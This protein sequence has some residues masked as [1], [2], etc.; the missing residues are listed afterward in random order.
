MTLL[1]RNPE[2]GPRKRRVIAL[3]M[4]SVLIATGGVVAV[5]APAAAAD[6]A[7]VPWMDPAKSADERAQALLDASSQHQKYRWLV[8]Q[9]ANSPQQTTWFGGVVYPVQ[10]ECTPTVIYANGP[11]G[12]YGSRGTTAWP[13][14]IAVAATWDLALGQQKA[15]AHG[16]ESF[17]KRSAVVLGPG[18]A[19]GRTPLSGRGS[20]YFGEDPLLSGLMAAANVRGLENREDGKPVI[21]NL[22]HYVANEQETD[23]EESSSNVDERTLR[24]VYD[25][26]YEIAVKES[27][28]GSIMCSY[29]QVN[30]VYACE[31][32]ILTTSI[33][34]E[35]GFEG[36]VMSDFG[37]VHST[38][39]SLNA[40]LDQELNRPVWF[41]PAKL[42]AAL[43]A[44]EITQQRI[45]EAAFRVVRSYIEG[46][47]FDH[48]VPTAPVADVSTAEHKQL[49][50]QIAEESTVLL[51]NDDALPLANDAATVA[52]IGQTASTVA[53]GGVSAKTGCAW[54]LVF[55]RGTALNC[56]AIAAPLDSITA[57]VEAAGG[58]VVYDSG[59]DPAQAAAVAAE[60]DV[61]IVFGHYTMGET[62]DLTDLRLDAN[63]D[64]LIEAV[65]A[66]SDKTVAV[67]NAGS[68]VEM[69]WIGDVDAVLHAW[70]SGEQF[71][72]AL[73][74]L[75]W[76]D[77][78]PSGKLP[79]TF[80]VSL[81]DTPTNTPQQYPGVFADGSTT[82]PEGST[83]IRQ[84]SYSEGLQVGYK[85]YDEQ[86]IEPLFE[87]GHGLS[88]TSFEYSALDVQNAADAAA[89]TVTSTV[90]FTVRNAGDAAGAEVPQVY[91][92]LPDAAGEPGKRLVG[93][94]RVELAPG[95][96]KRVEVVLASASSNQPFS[97]WDVDADAW[98]IVDG[99]YGIS[100]G[101]SSRDL[102][103]QTTTAI[104]I[105]APVATTPPSIAGKPQPGGKLTA[106]PGVWSEEGLTF[107]YQWLR[108]GEA[109]GGATHREYRVTGADRG[110]ALTVRVT[111][112][113]ATGPAGVAE[114]APVV[115]Q[116]SAIVLV[117]PNRIVGDSRTEFTIQVDVRPLAR[118]VVAEGTVVV[119]VDGETFEAELADGTATV[120]IGTRDRGVH[121]I[122]VAYSGGGT[123]L[124]AKGVSLIVVLR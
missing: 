5:A 36:Y 27:D 106:D 67:L 51:K 23:R 63:G 123:V 89:G 24:Q 108:D 80:P 11:D 78:N 81:A 107:S 87:F 94:D 68:A 20:E 48:P 65:A 30:G 84:V 102:P 25:L 112:T 32:D 93:F 74:G 95:E 97:I 3:L 115:V 60:A 14:P 96:E 37:S 47:L 69:P 41:T 105:T 98:R 91:L 44:G 43:A 119:K 85:W 2:A 92:T 34:D 1:K 111:A 38:A 52:V 33:R 73:A 99:D 26:P 82:R 19:S 54:Y 6:C 71:G 122:S 8:E 55:I 59:A 101:S 77:V 90:S 12:V 45:D 40:G 86:G 49:A 53:T 10:V 18:I 13:G 57:K 120:S 109:I 28:P 39:E 75:L 29:N 83:E 100:V 104:D 17:D 31:N 15:E 110:H 64:A 66:A 7:T 21:A 121:R 76:G 103:L 113:P 50:R 46:D 35:M 118:D 72:P 116:T 61:S 56:D 9:P 4:G 88:Y 42:D 22:K 114:S 16:R 117:K 124:P 70:H 62:T 58:T 79:M